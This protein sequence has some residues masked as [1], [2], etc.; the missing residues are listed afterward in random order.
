MLIS[1]FMVAFEGPFRIFKIMNE[2]DLLLTGYYI[3][4]SPKLRLESLT[5]REKVSTV[6]IIEV[7]RT[8]WW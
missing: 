3:Y 8:S 1:T 2:L 5:V 4:S 6:V 7:I